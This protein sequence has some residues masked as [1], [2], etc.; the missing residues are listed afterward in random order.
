MF[1]LQT[2]LGDDQYVFTRLNRVYDAMPA[3][4]SLT[5][6]LFPRAPTPFDGQSHRY[7]LWQYVVTSFVSV[8]QAYENKNQAK[9]FSF[10]QLS[11]SN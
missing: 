4:Q 7:L 10:L 2:V 8:S 6:Q 3:S 5:H 11:A 9:S 1:V